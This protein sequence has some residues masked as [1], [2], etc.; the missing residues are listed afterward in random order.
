MFKKREQGK[1]LEGQFR[2]ILWNYRL[3]EQ[4]SKKII[5]IYRHIS[6]FTDF[7]ILNVVFSKHNFSKQ[8]LQLRN[9]LF[10]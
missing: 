3:M 7:K 8:L 5:L 4:I 1:K 6:N 10:L 2:E 9:L